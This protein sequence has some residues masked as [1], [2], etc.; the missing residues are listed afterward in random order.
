MIIPEKRELSM[1]KIVINGGK[2]L[3]GEVKISGSKN[4]SL[5][6]LIATLLT[7]EQCFIENVPQLE[8]INT[9]INL[10]ESLGKKVMT[11]KNAITV[12]QAEKPGTEA[13]YEIVSKMRAS[14]LVMGPLLSRFKKVQIS[15]PGGCEI[16]LRPI[17]I[18]LDGFKKMGAKCNMS[19][20]NVS[21][22]SQKLSNSRIVLDFPSVGATENLLMAATLVEGETLIEN[23]AMEPEI[24]D[25]ANFL[26]KMGARISG[27]GSKTII[28]NGVKKLA[29]AEYT[30]MPDRVEAGTYMISSAITGGAVKVMGSVYE[31]NESLINKI[32]LSGVR[33]TLG[34]GIVRIKGSRNVKPV[35]AETLV[36]PGFP[37][38]LQPMWMALMTTASGESLITETVFEN[39]FQTIAE[40]ARMG[41][42]IKL[43]GN[44]A[45]V[46]GVKKLNG[47]RVCAS[48]LRSAAALILAGL[49]ASG[50]TEVKGLEHLDRGYENIVH[51]LKKLGA[52]IK[53]VEE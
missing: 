4:A 37:T 14:V 46:K 38:D 35:D 15:L 45:V 40:F 23:A 2:R 51:K 30:V 28:I 8:D 41:A 25:L 7:E 48:D 5:P 52:D 18:H 31:H 53:R 10:L 16:G 39:R 3:T 6:I 32:K 26:K 36:Y 21:L 20:G 1:G 27:A 42:D 17:N 12:T 24:E 33:V 49:S 50:Q 34:S 11:V 43:K 44:C 19:H 13:P 47:A 29:G 22:K 9:V